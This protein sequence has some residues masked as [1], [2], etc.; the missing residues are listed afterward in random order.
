MRIIINLTHTK[1]TYRTSTICCH[2]TT[3]IKREAPTDLREGCKNLFK[4]IGGI[5]VT[6]ERQDTD[7]YG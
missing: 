5:H 7:N 4:R 1:Y 3:Y 2:P 6:P